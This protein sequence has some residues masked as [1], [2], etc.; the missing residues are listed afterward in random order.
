LNKKSLLSA[1]SAAI[2]IGGLVLA[3]AIRFG[4]VQAASASGDWSMF[5]SDPSRSGVGTDN[6]IGNSV[7]TPTQLWKT[8]ITWTMTGRHQTRDL[9]EPAVV[10]GVVYVGTRSYVYVNQYRSYVWINFYAFNATNG[11]EIWNYR[12][13]SCDSISSPAVVNGVVYFA[14]DRYICALKA[15]NGALLWN[16]SAG[17]VYSNPAVVQDRLFI[18]SGVTLLALDANNGYSIWNYTAEGAVYSPSVANGIVYVGSSDWNIYA[19]NASMGD[20]IWNYYA[21]DVL[22]VPSVANGVVYA[23]LQGG[24]NIHALNATK[25][26]KIWNYSL[27][28]GWNEGISPFAISNN[29]LYASYGGAGILYALNAAKGAKIWNIALGQEISAPT[30]VKDVIYLGAWNGLYALNAHN[31]EILWNYSKAGGFGSPVVVNGVA[32]V[33]DLYGGEDNQ[34]YAIAVP[35]PQLPEREPFPTMLVAIASIGLV[36]GISAGLLFY[37]KKRKR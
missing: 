32:Y 29:V 37:F 3:S 33:G 12:D 25:G 31:G 24:A 21:A 9:T 6:P 7:L 35:S 22:S 16:Y 26:A 28:D 34:V 23:P 5:R 27:W 17:M 18:G 1:F 30:V 13:D 14:T 19:F 15:S 36:A 20:K 11:A 2:L 8:N 10:D 4:T